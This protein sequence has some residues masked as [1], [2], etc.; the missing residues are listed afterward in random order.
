MTVTELRERMTHRELVEQM[1]YD[2]LLRE[3]A[4]EAALDRKLEAS[5]RSLMARS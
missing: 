5:Q 4:Q 2:K 3:A 1:T